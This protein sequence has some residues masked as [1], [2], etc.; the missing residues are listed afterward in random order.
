MNPTPKW[1][2]RIKW[3]SNRFM[4]R[5]RNL[6]RFYEMWIDEWES[7]GRCGS[8]YRIPVGW[9]TEIWIKINNGLNGCLCGDCAVLMAEKRGVK[10]SVNDINRMWLFDPNG[11][12]GKPQKIIWR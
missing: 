2:S 11:V 3:F 5:L 10:I 1:T 8:C 7:C 9:R 12:L 4:A 6:F